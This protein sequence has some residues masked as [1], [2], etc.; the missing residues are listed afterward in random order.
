MDIHDDIRE[1]MQ[2]LMDE[3]P[4]AVLMSVSMTN[5]VIQTSL[6]FAKGTDDPELMAAMRK[7]HDHIISNAINN[8]SSHGCPPER[9]TECFTAFMKYHDTI[10]LLSLVP[11]DCDVHAELTRQTSAHK[12][13]D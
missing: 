11:D 8:A 1:G 3:Y 12:T 9:Y 6:K 4:P 2:K 7:A 13:T 10:H 5:L